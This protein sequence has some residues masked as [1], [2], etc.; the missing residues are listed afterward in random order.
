[1]RVRQEGL[2]AVARPLHRASDALGRP[3]ADRLL[4]IDE[5]LGAESAADVGGDDAELVLG[6][7]ADEGGEHETGDMRVLRG[8][9]KRVGL[10]ARIVVADGRPRLH[11]VRD[12]AVVDDLEPR[13][14]LGRPEG[15]V[16]RS[17]VA[18]VPL[19]D[20]VVRGD[21]VHLRS[22]LQLRPGGIGDGRKHLIVDDDGLGSV[23]GLRHRFGDDDG[24]MVADVTDLALGE[25]R[26]GARLHRRAV[27]GMDHPATDQAT[28][29][30]GGEVLA[31]EDPDHS[32]H[33]PGGGRVDAA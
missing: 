31:G 2:R 16:G 10:G 24:D 22:A 18:E 3:D 32:R 4:G 7:D 17:L 29:L 20:R 12:E 28:D 11:G 1:M 14:V 21:L 23:L 25:R 33:G 27:L 26:V 13:D 9:V 6:R 5:D 15:G 30:V 8:R 19:E